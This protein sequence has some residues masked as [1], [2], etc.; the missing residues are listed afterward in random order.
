MSKVPLLTGLLGVAMAATLGAQSGDT[1]PGHD[2]NVF[3][4]N[5]RPLIQKKQK[6]P[7][8]RTLSGKVVDDSGQ[9]LANAVVTLTNGKT[10]E[11]RTFFTKKDGRYNFEDLSFS[12][13]YE[14]RARY[15]DQQ[16]EARKLS[17]YDRMANVVRILEVGDSDSKPEQ[18]AAAPKK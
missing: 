6:A 1:N 10:G 4:D 13:D 15:K 17:Q 2:P 16:S 18:T 3:L 8:S 14:V 7:T 11:K 5:H 12:I 9:P